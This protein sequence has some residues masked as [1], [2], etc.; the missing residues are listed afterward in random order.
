MLNIASENLVHYS[1]QQLTDARRDLV[2]IVRHTPS[3]ATL[4]R[5]YNADCALLAAGAEMLT[6]QDE[7]V[8]SFESIHAR[9]AWLAKRPIERTLLRSSYKASRSCTL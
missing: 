4:Q 7:Q 1:P 3:P 5:A 8:L 9:M 6:P 2:A